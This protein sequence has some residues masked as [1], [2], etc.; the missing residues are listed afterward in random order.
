MTSRAR[1][2]S[3]ITVFGVRVRFEAYDINLLDFAIAQ[4]PDSGVL[5]C[6]GD[7]RSVSVTLAVR[8]GEYLPAPAVSSIENS[9]LTAA[10]DHVNSY[11]DGLAG[12]GRC[13]CQREH[14]DSPAAAEAIN[15]VVLFLVAHA[16]RIPVHAS[17]FMLG[18]TAIVLA[19]RSGSGKSS[20]AHAAN[21]K[22]LPV[23]SDDTL[24]VQTEPRLRIW[25]LPKAIHLLEEDTP[26]E[27]GREMRF[28]SGRWKHVVPITRP[29]HAADSAILFVL[30]RGDAIALEPMPSEDAVS[31]LTDSPEPGYEFY[32]PQSAATIRALARAGCWKLTLSRDPDAAVDVLCAHLTGTEP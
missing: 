6:S 25:A 28:R 18:D 13:V 22:G 24:Y 8:D 31:E 29:L 14:V 1:I 12:E 30:D 2:Y 15:T 4:F 16:G 9:R 20:L 26:D 11:A 10:S 5:K 32:G 27:T 17:A 23:L 7:G 21:R 3:D 19:G